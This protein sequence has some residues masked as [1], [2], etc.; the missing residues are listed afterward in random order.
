MYIIVY[1][2]LV[3]FL[4]VKMNSFPVP[5]P[6]PLD[7]ED[8]NEVTIIARSAA[9]QD[10]NIPQKWR[11]TL[12]KPIPVVK[13]TGTRTNGE[14]CTRWS[15]MGTTVCYVHGAQLPVVK[16]AAAAR[17]EA[18][19]LSFMG[20]SAEAFEVLESLMQ[21]GV[22]E[23]IRLK[24]A[25]EIL[26]RAGLKAGMEVNVTLEH[27]GSPL[28]DI[29]NQLEIIAGNKEPILDPEEIFDAEEIE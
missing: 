28:E 9:Q 22:A 26:D 24:A 29:M 21:P 8:N 18:A 7:G 25:T 4:V 17:V 2:I 20:S 15:V 1:I 10:S 19:R 6:P 27:V 5:P 14:P 12:A 3:R 16:K 23:G 11:P 13:C